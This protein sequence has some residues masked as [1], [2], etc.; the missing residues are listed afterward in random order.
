[1]MTV[2][3]LLSEEEK[4]KLK[5]FVS[6]DWEEEWKQ[7]SKETDST[8]PNPLDPAIIEDNL[9]PLFDWHRKK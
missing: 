1:M 2:N 5:Q 4:S 3:P 6:V 9:K 8:P 7:S